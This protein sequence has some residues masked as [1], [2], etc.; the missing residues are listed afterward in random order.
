MKHSFFILLLFL[1]GC[2]PHVYRARQFN[3]AC[4][5]LFVN[6][7]EG[8]EKG[9]VAPGMYP[10]EQWWTFFQDPEL[11]RLIE[12]ALDSHPDIK[13]AQSRIYRAREVALDARSP[14]FPHFFLY[15]D[16]ERDKYSLFSYQTFGMKAFEYLADATL[17]LSSAL[18]ELD[19]WNKNRNTYYAT[20]NEL[21]AGYADYAQAKLLLS[22]TL[23]SIYFALQYNLE[24]LGIGEVRLT[25]REE[26]GKLLR[27]RFESGVIATFELYE[28][29][30]LIQRIK[31]YVLQQKGL[32]DI[33]LHAIS[34]LVAHPGCG[35]IEP[36]A[37]FDTPLP[38]PTTLPIDLLAR[39]PDIAA[40]KYLIEASA[41]RVAVAKARFFPQIDLLGFIGFTSIKLA[42][43]FTN[44]AMAWN[45][46]SQGALPL[47]TGLQLES[48]VGIAREEVEIAVET[49]N[50][51]VLNAV[52]QVSDALTELTIANQRLQVLK[53]GIEDADVLYGL[54]KQRYHNA[55][56]NRLKVL[57]SFEVLLMQKQLAATVQL[58]R[59][60]AAVSLI[61]AIGGGYGG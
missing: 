22:T 41:F 34:A 33:N 53:K 13:I 9:S 28:N 32:I 30:L 55:L 24:L 14:L 58:E 38:L 39:R 31:D 7:Q 45:V 5:D 29:D 6:V 57:E 4:T 52:Q 23:A 56:N 49:Y 42:Q 10:N 17:Y 59:F 47:F 54:T 60:Q 43:L 50:Q 20:L 8:F 35:C 36:G 25:A 40:Q 2:S 11:N 27:K 19:I 37:V 18:F 61:Q 12:L 1:T 15:G 21:F 46:E 26:L 48:R 44:K 16:I 3:T 51:L